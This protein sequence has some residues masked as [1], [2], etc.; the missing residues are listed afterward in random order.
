M[1][2]HR[3]ILSLFCLPL[4]SL[5]L[6]LPASATFSQATTNSWHQVPSPN[7][8][9]YFNIVR[10]IDGLSPNE[11]WAVGEYQTS[12]PGLVQF[13]SSNLIMRW[14]GTFWTSFNIQNFST[15]KNSFWD[16]EAVSPSDVWA[17][18]D[19]AGPGGGAQTQIAHWDG[20]SWT[21]Q[22]VTVATG[23][24]YLWSV[25]AISANDIWAVGGRADIINDPC[26]S[27]HYDGSTWTEIPVPTVG[28]RRNRFLAVDGLTANDVWA[29]G[30]YG[31]YAGH[32]KHLIMHWDGS[33]WTHSPVPAAIDTTLGELLDV[34]MVSANDVWAV[35]E[36]LTGGMF[37]LHWDGSS[38]TE[39][40]SNT[41]GGALAAF[42]PND[43][44]AVGGNIG[45]WNGS[46]WTLIDSL[47]HLPSPALATVTK[48]PNGE[49]W[50]AGRTI[51]ANNVFRTLVYRFSAGG[52]QL[53]VNASATSVAPG[54]SVQLTAQ[55]AQP[56]TYT[57]RWSPG[58]SLNDSTIANPVAT[59]ATTTHY[60]L[61]V[62]DAAGN[63]VQGAITLRVMLGAEAETAIADNVSIFP[64]PFDGEVFVQVK[65]EKPHDVQLTLT[66]ALG[67]IIY[68][69][70]AY[71]TNGINQLPLY[72]GHMAKG[73]YVLTSKSGDSVQHLKLQHR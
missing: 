53:S 12:P 11:I 40:P 2:S 27:Y 39:I 25:D 33:T 44:Y 1:K 8:S 72:T 3:N 34:H 54:A 52:Q 45:H 67:R 20:T 21:S 18:G 7:P 43:I 10:G 46:S 71:L 16:V 5:C 23:T 68:Q 14:N 36:I 66:D 48:L 29:V 59:P 62:T 15:I 38:W 32:F 9:P 56:G 42:A 41:G 70:Q 61:N 47:D 4:I 57:Y 60:T 51:D 26:F 64:N 19:F 58:A 28:T 73:L 55:L 22:A 17:V 35:G 31:D 13:T 63:S 49:I 30:S 69:K 6:L 24:S 50:A 37:M 65:T